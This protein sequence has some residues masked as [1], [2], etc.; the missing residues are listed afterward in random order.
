[1]PKPKESGKLQENEELKQQR[2]TKKKNTNTNTRKQHSSNTP[3][4]RA[5]AEN[6]KFNTQFYAKESKVCNKN[7]KQF[8]VKE[9]T[10]KK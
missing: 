8:V 4:K 6:E 9:Y 5:S 10:V 1:M 2:K 7:S 3:E